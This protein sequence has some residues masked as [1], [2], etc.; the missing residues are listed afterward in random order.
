MNLRI[1]VIICFSMMA[2]SCGQNNE[3]REQK[4]RLSQVNFQLPFNACTGSRMLGSNQIIYEVGSVFGKP[5]LAITVR[6]PKS[7]C[8][9]WDKDCTVQ[10]VGLTNQGKD[11]WSGVTATGSAVNL[12][13]GKNAY[14][15]THAGAK[16]S[17]PCLPTDGAGR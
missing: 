9:R 17:L 16:T 15:I 6:S 12:K 11:T 5:N 1:I 10:E 8:F 7:N 3:G 2:V 14:V 4:S 13:Y